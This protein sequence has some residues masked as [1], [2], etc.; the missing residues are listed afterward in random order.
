MFKDPTVSGFTGAII[1]IDESQTRF[2]EPQ[3]LIVCERVDAL[4]LMDTFE[5]Y[6]HSDFGN[7]CDMARR[8]RIEW[9]VFIEAEHVQ[10]FNIVLVQLAIDD[11]PAES[12][13][14]PDRSFGG[15]VED[16]A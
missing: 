11:Q 4:G 8:Q 13:S 1:S 10:S 14:L 9:R 7:R 3:G 2:F 6:R 12:V 16:I 5:R 15:P